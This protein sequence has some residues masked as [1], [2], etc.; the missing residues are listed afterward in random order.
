MHPMIASWNEVAEAF[1]QRLDAVSADQ[2]ETRSPCD[3]W[4]C[5]ELIEHTVTVQH[6][7]GAQLGV[8][9]PEGDASTSWSGFRQAMV[10]AMS[11]EG[12]LETE[13]ETPFGKRPVAEAM[14]IPT[15]DLL[16]HTWD[17]SRTIGHD[18]ALPAA[19]VTHAFEQ[20]K[21]MDAML[22]GRGVFADKVD[23]AADASE[24]DQFIAFT[25]RQ[26]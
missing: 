23:V 13:I 21:P 15:L 6:G 3:E 20:I 16:V 5:D 8:E 17:L 12:G 26:P 7:V 2:S 14:G 25:G 9:V 1:G 19:A 24:Q 22:R 4:N 18:D 10:A 11:A